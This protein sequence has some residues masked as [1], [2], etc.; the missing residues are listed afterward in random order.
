MRAIVNAALEQQWNTIVSGTTLGT[1]SEKSSFTIDEATSDAVRIT[2]N[3][4][5]SMTIRRAA[6][7]AALLYL[8]EHGHHSTNNPCEIRSSQTHELAGPLCRAAREANQPGT[9]GTRVITYVLPILKIMG[10]V[11]IDH[12]SRPGTTWAI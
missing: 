7:E 9:G 12:E 8:V 3:G 10:L 4:E 11:E 5:T 2:T 6:F 1:P